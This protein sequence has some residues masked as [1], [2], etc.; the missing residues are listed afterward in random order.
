ML[1]VIIGETFIKRL[2]IICLT[3]MDTKEGT[4]A[5]EEIGYW[6]TGLLGYWVIGLLG[7]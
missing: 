2:L 1:L 3:T 6:V 7:Y 5:T 4:K